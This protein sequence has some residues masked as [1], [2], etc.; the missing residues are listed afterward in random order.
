MS[1]YRF[2]AKNHIHEL[3]VNGEWKPLIGTSSVMGVVA[4]PLTWW[5]AGMACEQFGWLNPKKA[6]PEERRKKA[7]EVLA[8]LRAADLETYI[9]MLDRAYRAHDS[10]KN[11][12]ADAGT[13]MHAELEAYV[14]ACMVVGSP[15]GLDYKTNHRAAQLFAE[16]SRNNVKRFL[17]SE[18]HTYSEKHWLGGISDA[19]AELKNGA[20][21]LIDFKSSK[22]AYPTHF[23]QI[24]GYDIQL[25]EN[26]GLTADGEPVLGPVKV[27]CHIVFPFGAEKPEAQ[28][29]YDVE[30]DREAFLAA[31]VLHKKQNEIKNT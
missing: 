30:S 27:D 22:E 23:W 5:A 31:L 2:N 19:G 26:G 16:W 3:N 29:R 28:V 12:A 18:V 4:K 1:P 14:K 24:G 10:A 15:Q 13:D 9:G 7:E 25:Q 6:S 11:K 17:W 20:I 8:K 21:A